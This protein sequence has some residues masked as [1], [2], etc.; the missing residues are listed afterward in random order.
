MTG[1]LVNAGAI[2]LGGIIGLII[3]TKL[4]KSI[5]K[6]VFQGIGLFTLF[7][8]VKMA[9]ETDNYLIMIFSMVV[10]GIIGQAANFDAL[11]NGWGEK[12]KNR[13]KSKNDR[14]TEGLVTAFL[15]Y[16][17]GSLTVL[18]AIEEGLGNTPNLLYAKSLLDGVSSIALTVALG[19]GV[20]FSI[21]PLLIYQGGLT[22]LA[23]WLGDYFAEA[24]INE[25]TAVGGLLLLGLGIN[26]LEISH[27]KILN[28]LPALI[29]VV[30]ISYFFI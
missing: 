13:L 7:L 29:V 24:I 5:V 22:L 9:M 21:I 1:T 8:G 20:I 27:I 2:V 3:H 23:A 10:G 14:F 16:C 19:Y 26:I 11:I 15:L 18:G 6:I 28:L 30:I 12:L 4:P 17:M 25:L